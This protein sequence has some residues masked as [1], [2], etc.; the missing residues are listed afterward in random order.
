MEACLSWVLG[1]S[2]KASQH[3]A[4]AID[5]AR[6]N[7]FAND[8]GFC[9]EL[10]GRFYQKTRKWDRAVACFSDAR[11]AYVQWGAAAKVRHLEESCPEIFPS[12]GRS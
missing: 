10:S 8:V 1:H 9:C 11:F 12:A 6:R 4:Q 2:L 7:G 5:L 3:F